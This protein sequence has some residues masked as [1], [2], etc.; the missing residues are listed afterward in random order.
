MNDTGRTEPSFE[1][2]KLANMWRQL[3]VALL[4]E[5]F[6]EQQSMRLLECMIES[7]TEGYEE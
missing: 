4:Y 3:Y 5:G 7:N 6:S 2:R 1:A